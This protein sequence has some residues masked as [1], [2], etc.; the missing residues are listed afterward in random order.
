[1]IKAKRN[2][3]FLLAYVENTDTSKPIIIVHDSPNAVPKLLL[4]LKHVPKI[5]FITQKGKKLVT[6]NLTKKDIKTDVLNRIER[7]GLTTKE[8]IQ[9]Y[10]ILKVKMPE[11][12]KP[13]ATKNKSSNKGTNK[14]KASG[15]RK[16]VKR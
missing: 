11:I 15:T 10:E 7:G 14:R 5:K 16:K 9:L 3:G 4:T 2:L 8:K 6:S 12:L 13:N 1:M